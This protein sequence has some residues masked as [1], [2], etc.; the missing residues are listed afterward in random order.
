MRTILLR[1]HFL[2]DNAML[3]L[4]YDAHSITYIFDK[5]YP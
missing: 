2:L 1:Y 4:I 3:H 5:I